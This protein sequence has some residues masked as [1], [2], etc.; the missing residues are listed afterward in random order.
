MST[1]GRSRKPR[2]T[3]MDAAIDAMAPFGFLEQLVRGKV[4]DL[5]REYG[6]DVGWPF[7]E[8]D[9][10]KLL[11]DSLLDQQEEEDKRSTRDGNGSA[12]L[13]EP[14]KDGRSGNF[15]PAADAGPSCLT[16]A[17]RCL[18]VIDA[19]VQTSDTDSGDHTPPAQ[20]CDEVRMLNDAGESCVSQQLPQTALDLTLKSSLPT[21]PLDSSPV[22]S[23]PPVL[24]LSEALPKSC[25]P[26]VPSLPPA[27]I[28]QP[29]RKKPCFG[30]ISDDDDDTEDFIILTP[31]PLKTK[32]RKRKVRWD[33]RP[34]D[35]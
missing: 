8:A 5:L 10:Y 31:A 24:P 1:R 33:L 21:E 12:L 13:D 2:L 4:K 32:G 7:I 35:M 29:K 23:H 14:Q 28:L 6:G 30:W 22:I 15:P 9:A 25:L 26:L 11:I 18:E 20:N 34:E 16:P 19:A 27:S 3:R 17:S